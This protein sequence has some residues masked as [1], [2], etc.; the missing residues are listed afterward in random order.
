M[1]S[2]A[3]RFAAALIAVEGELDWGA[4]GAAYC[5]GDGQ[6][7]FA[8]DQIEAMRDAGLLLADDVAERLGGL[9]ALSPAI[10]IYVG[11]GV[12]ELAP[13]VCEAVVFGR[14]V[15]LVGLPGPELDA[16]GRAFGV[17]S[18]RLG[19]PLPRVVGEPLEHLSVGPA[20]HGWL[21]SVLTDPDAFPALHDALYE[22]S[23]DQATGRGAVE[24]EL[25]RARRLVDALLDRLAL[26]A[27]LT[28]TD[29]E[30]AIVGPWCE[31]RGL[32]LVV[33]EL[34]RLSGVVGDPVRTCELRARA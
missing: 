14:E 13:M 31:E 32:E 3:E 22:R 29:E 28:T 26:P 33:P 24:E 1:R 5:E 12:A 7:F 10:S 19:V 21:V 2:S 4:L 20:S 6:E 8:P 25:P 16:L 18:A 34:A 30:L 15:W 11:A 23:G 9:P 27:V 17:V